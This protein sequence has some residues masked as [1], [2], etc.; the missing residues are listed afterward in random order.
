[1]ANRI[2]EAKEF[3]AEFRQHAELVCD[4]S[5]RKNKHIL[6]IGSKQMNID[7][8]VEVI[9]AMKAKYE[10]DGRALDKALIELHTPKGMR[11]YA[12]E[13]LGQMSRIS[14][15][16]GANAIEALWR[17]FGL[18]IPTGRKGRRNTYVAKNGATAMEW[19][20]VG[21]LKSGKT[22][23]AVRRDEAVQ[24]IIAKGRDVL[25]TRSTGEAYAETC[26]QYFKALPLEAAE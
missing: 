23:A 16:E 7:V 17:T 26:T 1:M 13:Q 3:R 5:Q 21:D 20:S 6:G 12:S 15:S 24:D 22:A 19:A 2:V 10:A 25:G 14:P 9:E 8:A 18:L 11:R 4:F